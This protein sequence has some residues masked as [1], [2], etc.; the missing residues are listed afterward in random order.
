MSEDKPKKPDESFWFEANGEKQDSEKQ[1]S[2]KPRRQNSSEE[3]RLLEAEYRAERALG[4]AT[5]A[6]EQALSSQQRAVASTSDAFLAQQELSKLERRFESDGKR[7]SESRRN[8]LKISAGLVAGAAI[9][10]VVQVPLYANLVSSRNEQ[11]RTLN[12]QLVQA[13]QQISSLQSQVSALTV[14]VDTTTGFLTLGVSEQAAV[15]AIAETIIPSD[16]SGPGAKEAGVIYFIDRQLASDYGRGANMFTDG[17]FF[18]TGQTGPV[19]VNGQTYSGGSPVVRVGAGTRFQYSLPMR[20]FWRTGIA[21]L[22]TYSNTAYGGKP[23]DAGPAGPVVQRAFELQRHTAGGFCVRDNIH[24]MGRLPDGPSLRRQPEH[25]RLAVHRFQRRE[26]GQRVQRGPHPETTHG[27]ER[28][29]QTSACKPCAVPES[30]IE[31]GSRPIL[32][33]F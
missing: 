20:E 22:E 16:S 18:L 11:V 12:T 15:E 3:N 19:T 2:E 14:R 23:A 26:P 33:Q 7:V 10:S 31:L 29:D 5:A 25:G 4:R 6:Q 24:D 30:P 13:D 21:A 27:G 8:F 9:A 28:G 32:Q 1:D 17:P